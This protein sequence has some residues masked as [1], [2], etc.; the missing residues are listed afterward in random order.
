MSNPALPLAAAQAARPLPL[1]GACPLPGLTLIEA[2]GEDAATF[3]H[4]Q[5]TQSVTDLGPGQ[6]RWAAWCSAKGRMLATLLL[7]SPAPGRVWALVNATQQPALRKRLQMFVL[8]SKVRLGEGP[9]GLRAWG[10]A[11]A[12]AAAALARAG[13]GPA[14]PAQP[15]AAW[16]AAAQDGGWLLRLP[17]AAGEPLDAPCPRALWLGEA[18]PAG[19]PDLAPEAWDW[20]ELA[21][22][23]VAVRPETAEAFIP[24]TLN[25]ERVGGV[26]FQKGC[27]P[28]QEIVARSQYR[29]TLKRRGLRVESQGPLAL[30]QVLVARDD[31]GQPAGLIAAAAPRPDGLGWSGFA[32]LKTAVLADPAVGLHLDSAE[33]PALRVLPPPYPL[34]AQDA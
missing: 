31:P 33:G 2:E 30:G 25:L 11:G 4:A 8:R 3:L 29:G 16:A 27:Y 19:L 6:A 24:Q 9:A 28:G 13:L 5:L 14:D 22:G 20:L 23:V 1:D 7:I 21:S 17:A 15:A 32:E 18:A 34:P 10:L 26:N 12:S